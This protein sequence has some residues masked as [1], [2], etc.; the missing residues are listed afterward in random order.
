TEGE[1]LFDE[2]GKETKLLESSVEFLRWF[3]AQMERSREF[4][5]RLAELELLVPRN[6]QMQRGEEKPEV[7]DG[8]FIIDEEKLRGLKDEQVLELF[9]NGYLFLIHAHLCSLSNA[10]RLLRMRVDRLA[11]ATASAA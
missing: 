3:H 11:A 2:E 5:K 4:T 6:I 7:F 8:F 9:R 1:P 10:D